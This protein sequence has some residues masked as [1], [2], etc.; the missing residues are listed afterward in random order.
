MGA[1]A[2][3][4]GAF[5]AAVLALMESPAYADSPADVQ[6][7]QTSAAIENLAVATYGKALTLPFIGGAD[8]VPVVKAFVTTTRHQHVE[9]A[10]AFNAAAKQLGG[11]AQT[12]PDPALTSVVSSADLTTPAGVVK[13]AIELENT[14]AQTY[15]ANT[16]ALT[17]KSARAVT[18]SI[19][20]VE[21]QHASVLYAVQALLAADMASAIALPPPDLAALAGRGRQ[22]RL[23]RLV[24]QDRCGASRRGRGCPVSTDP[25][26]VSE[27]ELAGDDRRRSTSCTARACPSWPTPSPRHRAQHRRVMTSR[28]GFLAGSGLVAGGLVLAACGSSSKST[29]TGGTTGATT[30]G[31]ATDSAMADR[32]RGRRAGDRAREPGRAGVPGRHRRGDG[33]QAGQGAARGGHVRQDR[34]DAAQGPRRCLERRPHRRR[35]AGGDRR[36]HDGEDR[37]SPI[38][39]LAKVTDVAGLAKLA[40]ALEDVA[41]ATY[42]NAHHRAQL[43][44]RHPDHGLDPAGRDA[45][46]GDPA[47]SCS[48][49]TRCRRP[50]APTTRGPQRLATRW[51]D[52]SR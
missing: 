42:L 49:S 47:T 21:A 5:G 35:Q 18:S 33:G 34:A 20:G 16:A 1:A 3:A 50:F 4:T 30:G 23:P 51:A 10:A 32:P 22:R 26:H 8:A 25:I 9:H 45:A 7:L 44:G 14:A 48:A 6:M 28:R 17:D 15:V 37:R 11:Q 29:A 46:R 13:L 38:P 31:T 41:A 19:M 12:K 52:V 36:R 2:V 39:A 40:L 27:A 43:E 24:L